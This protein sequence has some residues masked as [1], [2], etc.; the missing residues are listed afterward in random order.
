MRLG[1]FPDRLPSCEKG[2]DSAHR[3]PDGDETNQRELPDFQQE[4]AGN[5]QK[6]EFLDR[7][8]AD[9][10]RDAEFRDVIGRRIEIRI[11]LA[12]D[13]IDRCEKFIGMSLVHGDRFIARNTEQV[14][15]PFIAQMPQDPW[16]AYLAGRYTFLAP[17]DPA[18]GLR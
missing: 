1:R 11:F 13:E 15:G 12:A 4:Y 14:F 18:D 6:P 3:R 9:K 10:S 16:A 7:Q 8:S 5:S 2:F 17:T